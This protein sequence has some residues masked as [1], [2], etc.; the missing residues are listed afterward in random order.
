M[1]SRASQS[2]SERDFGRQRDVKILAP[3]T[4]IKRHEGNIDSESSQGQIPYSL[5]PRRHCNGSKD[6]DSVIALLL[7]SRS[8]DGK[9]SLLRIHKDKEI[10]RGIFLVVLVPFTNALPLSFCSEEGKESLLAIYGDK[11]GPRRNSL[12]VVVHEACALPPRTC[13]ED[14]KESLLRIHGDQEFL[15]RFVLGQKC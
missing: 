1:A 8:E 6:L 15:E 5:P 12:V 14:G 4:Q 13:S 9:E 2:V 10:P 7:G 3:K 11:Q